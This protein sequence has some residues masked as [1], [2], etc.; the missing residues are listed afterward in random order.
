MNPVRPRGLLL[1]V[2]V[3]LFR[4][5]WEMIEEFEVWAGV[6]AGTIPWRGPLDPVGDPLWQR[7]LAGEITEHDYWFAFAVACETAGVDPF[8]YDHVMRAVFQ[9]GYTDI[10]RPEA[11]D[12]VARCRE[13]GL[14][15]GLLTNELV[16]LHGEEWVSAFHYFE[17]F[18]PIVD[19]E[20]LGTRKPAPEPY[21]AAL[22][23]LGMTAEEVV[24]V[25]DNPLYVEGAERL[26]ITA[27]WLD[28]TDPTA[29]FERAG[30]L[31]GL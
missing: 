15:V 30:E 11:R 24:F 21:L 9:A 26:G 7:H 18:D 8:P 5:A 23:G 1:D 16:A 27:V 2:G 6:P 25:D 17:H 4:S 19:A 10:V 14:P 12:L 22:G 29:P 3:V 13:A 31:L 20:R 28:V